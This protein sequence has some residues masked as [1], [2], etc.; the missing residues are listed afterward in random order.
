MATHHVSEDVVVADHADD[1][2]RKLDADVIKKAAK[3]DAAEHKMTIRE[4][5]QTHKKA[6]FWS[7][8]LSGAS[9]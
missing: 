1:L 4:A 7:M 8:A 5:F 6:I 3:A 9:S 2:A